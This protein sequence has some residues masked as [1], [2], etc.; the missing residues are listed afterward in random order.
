MRPYSPEHHFELT[1]ENKEKIIIET[2]GSPEFH[3][4]I[5]EISSRYD[6][7]FEKAFSGEINHQ[8][9]EELSFIILK[10]RA[11]LKFYFSLLSE[12]K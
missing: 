4:E 12:R 1:P 5:K 10:S 8:P 2:F 7:F 9:L 3:K 6:E 11:N